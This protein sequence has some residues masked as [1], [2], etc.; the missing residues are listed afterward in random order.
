MPVLVVSGAVLLVVVAVALL[1]YFIH[2][3]ATRTQAAYIMA[4]VAT[5]TLD[6]ID[7]QSMP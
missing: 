6:K 1:V 3:I 5:E 2:H 7:R 4:A